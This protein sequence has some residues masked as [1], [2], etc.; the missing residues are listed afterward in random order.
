MQRI[1]IGGLALT[2]SLGMTGVSVADESVLT[3]PLQQSSLHSALAQRSLMLDVTHAGNAL[4][5]VGERGFVLRSEDG[6]QS[7]QQVDTPVSVTLTRVVFP[8]P[9]Q[10]WAVG[11]AGVVLHTG[12]GGRSWKLQ[13]EGRQASQLVVEAAQKRFELEPNALNEKRASSARSLLEDGPD[14]P[15]LDVH[16]FDDAHGIVV[17]AYGL[18]FATDNGGNSWH[19][20]DQRLENPGAMHLYGIQQIDDKLFIVGEQG[21]LL[22][23]SDQGAT[24]ETLTSPA[25]GTL[26]GL[27][28]TGQHGLLAFGLRGKS[29]FSNDAGDSWQPV[30]NPSPITITAG[31]LLSDGST[32]LVDESGRL[33]TSKDPKHGF[34]A[35]TL[36]EPSYLTGLIE[37]GAGKLVLSSARGVSRINLDE[38]NRSATREQ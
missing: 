26:F 22:R 12:D 2:L 38:L 11:H 29:Y 25:T 30:A 33:L 3:E 1:L 10:G 27:V 36:P 31:T 5:A 20:I 32:L 21:L 4:V 18:A 8:T 16:F 15:F 19:P 28:P 6:G 17:G 37:L 35:I 34:T 7:W 24:F 13:L 14:K 9:E 23:S